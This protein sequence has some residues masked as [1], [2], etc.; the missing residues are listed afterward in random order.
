VQDVL[1]QLGDE[2]GAMFLAC[3]HGVLRQTVSFRVIQIAEFAHGLATRVG[4]GQALLH[5][6]ARAH[7]E[8]ETELVIEVRAPTRRRAARQTQEL[9]NAGA[10]I[11]SSTLNTASTYV[12]HVAAS[13]RSC[14]RPSVVSA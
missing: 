10:H 14:F 13:A 7:V 4:L 12:R 2:I 5:E 9:P 11:G 1:A 6:L 8:V 3:A